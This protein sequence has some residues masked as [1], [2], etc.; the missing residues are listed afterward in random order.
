MVDAG[1]SSFPIPNSFKPNPR[2]SFKVSNIPLSKGWA[3]IGPV[4]NL[5][6]GWL[7]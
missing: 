5:H 1:D 3:M 7:P 4:G 2:L 6:L